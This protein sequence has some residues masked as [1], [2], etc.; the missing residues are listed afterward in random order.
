M[1][2]I[3]NT[4]KIAVVFEAVKITRIYNIMPLLF[5]LFVKFF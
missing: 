5:L 1:S 2:V 4:L 3:S